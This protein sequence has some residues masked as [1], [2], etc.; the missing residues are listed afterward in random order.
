MELVVVVIALALIEYMYITMQVGFGRGKYD[1]PAPAISGNPTWERLYR[2]QMNTVEQLIIFVPS[3]WFFG[4]YVSAPIAAGIGVVFIV[5][6]FLYFTSYV[7]DP[8]KR[9]VGFVMGFAS[10]VTLVLGSLIG[11]ALRLF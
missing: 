9:T 8:E 1:V 10:N 7:K 5:G 11:A 3:V 6:R 4:T 2:V